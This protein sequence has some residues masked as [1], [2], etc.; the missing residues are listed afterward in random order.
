MEPVR[1]EKSLLE[2]DI[3]RWRGGVPFF[4]VFK[5]FSKLKKG[6]PKQVTFF[7]ALPFILITHETAQG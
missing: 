5:G 3:H 4:F 2:H 1:Q 6:T 7:L